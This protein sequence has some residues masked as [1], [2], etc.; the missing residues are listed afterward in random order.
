M[1]SSIT[2][3]SSRITFLYALF[4]SHFIR[5]LGYGWPSIQG[6]PL[7]YADRVVT[8]PVLLTRLETF[9][10]QLPESDYYEPSVLLIA[11]VTENISILDL[12]HDKNQYLLNQLRSNIRNNNNSLSDNKIKKSFL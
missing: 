10:K 1:I 6:G 7:F 4:L 11:M 2:A 12:Q 3:L 8:L 9:S 5:I